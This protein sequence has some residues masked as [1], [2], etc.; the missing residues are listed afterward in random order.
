[1]SDFDFG[2]A[3]AR[4]DFI[5]LRTKSNAALPRIH[6]MCRQQL[7]HYVQEGERIESKLQKMQF[8][9]CSQ[10]LEDRRMRLL[11]RVEHLL[12]NLRGD[13][14]VPRAGRM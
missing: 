9:H 12:E 11:A 5:A 3:C 6:T 13:L 14:V 4:Q 7:E 8:G 10:E 1:M 2:L